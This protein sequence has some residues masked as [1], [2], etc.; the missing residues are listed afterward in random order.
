MK[1]ITILFIISYLLITGCASNCMEYA[2][3]TTAA[4]TEKDLKR[5]EDWGLKALNSEACF[6]ETNAL[7][8]YFLATEVYLKQNNYTK[9][10]EMLTIAEDRNAAQPLERPFKLGDTPIRTIGEGVQA[11]REQ[12]WVNIYNKAVELI[13]K[14]K[15]E[16]AKRQIEIAI[17]INPKK[18]ENYSTLSAID[19]TNQNYESAISTINRGLDIDKYDPMLNERMADIFQIQNKLNSAKE[20]YLNAIKYSDN[21]GPIMR[22]L[23]G[24]YIDLEETQQ[25]I[26]YSNQLMNKYPDD[27]DLYYNVGVLYQRLASQLYDK[28][29]N[30]FNNMDDSY[31]NEKIISLYKSYKLAREYSYNARDYYLQASD[32]ENE[33]NES[34]TSG[35]KEMKRIMKL[36]DDMFIPGIRKTAKDQ[37]ISLD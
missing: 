7:A 32:L 16:E 1:K 15:I 29:L 11:Y 22:K 10:A 37:G 14:E 34:T 35:A 12:E 2:S 18:I 25:A 4:R 21:P 19:V 26:D 24:V 5:A 28:N 36:I 27:P 31:S 33:E 9:M 13:Q 20:L 23:L 6:P 8:P 30:D 17:L 3:A